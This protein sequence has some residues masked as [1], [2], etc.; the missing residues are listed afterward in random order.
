MFAKSSS[1]SVDS[2]MEDETMRSLSTSST[3]HRTLLASWLPPYAASLAYAAANVVFWF[4][5]LREL[6]RREMY[7]KV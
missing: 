3:L 6:D 2:R 7:L 5:I 4:F 1:I